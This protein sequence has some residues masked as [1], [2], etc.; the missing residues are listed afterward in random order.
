M[1]VLGGGAPS[2]LKGEYKAK[3]KK[4]SNIE[5]RM[6]NNE[7]S[8]FDF[9]LNSAFDIQNS[10]FDIFFKT[11]VHAFNFCSPAMLSGLVYAGLCLPLTIK[12]VY[13]SLHF[14]NEF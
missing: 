10:V 7:V 2:H 14:F 12:K 9:R 1:K 6:M 11:I 4:I 13:K 8:Y 5:F 3:G